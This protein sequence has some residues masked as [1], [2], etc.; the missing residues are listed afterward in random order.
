MPVTAS[1]TVS[2]SCPEP[3]PEDGDVF[4]FVLTSDVTINNSEATEQVVTVMSRIAVR[5]GDLESETKEVTCPPQSSTTNSIEISTTQTLYRP[6]KNYN[7]EVKVLDAAG[8]QLEL[9][10]EIC[11]VFVE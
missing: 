5:S 10:R 7:G 2:L 6:G 9:E 3:F 1:A 4:E 8:S 11:E